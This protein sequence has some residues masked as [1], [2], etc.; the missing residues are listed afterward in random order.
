M[1]RIGITIIVDADNIKAHLDSGQLQPGTQA[2]PTNLG[3]NAASDNYL[4]MIA[5]RGVVSSGQEGSSELTITANVGDTI[6]WSMNTLLFNTKY[7]PFIYDSR[8]NPS[9]GL[10]PTQYLNITTTNYIPPGSNPT[11]PTQK[12]TSQLYVAMAT[13][14]KSGQ[15]IQYVLSFKLIDNATGNVIGYFS[16]DPFIVI[17]F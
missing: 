9:N 12:V 4:Y 13:V 11:A 1:A 3:A 15:K 6:Q 7:T 10:S 16:W 17:P 14:V 8:F 5:K 2:S